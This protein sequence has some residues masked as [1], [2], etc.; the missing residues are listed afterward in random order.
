MPHVEMG[1][2]GTTKAVAVH[3][4]VPANRGPQKLAI[5]QYDVALG[6]IATFGS[7]EQA[8][9]AA[10][11]P[12]DGYRS[13]EVVASDSYFLRMKALKAYLLGDLS[14]AKSQHD[15]FARKGRGCAG[16]E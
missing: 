10:Q 4:R 11:Y 2:D 6:T 3:E 9:R 12:E 8:V 16:Q 14:A 7:R 15:G 5:H 13:S 1:P